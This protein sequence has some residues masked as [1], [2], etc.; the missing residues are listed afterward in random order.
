MSYYTADTLSQNVDNYNRNA[1]IQV[2]TGTNVQA[3]FLD[4]SNFK[5][6]FVDDTF[7]FIYESEKAV[8][9]IDGLED[10]P[11][12]FY[13]LVI[14][15][16]KE[17]INALI[18]CEEN[19]FTQ[20][21][22]QFNFCITNIFAIKDKSEFVNDIDQVLVPFEFD[23]DTDDVV[24]AIKAHGLMILIKQNPDCWLSFTELMQSKVNFVFFEY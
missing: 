24:S 8:D 3:K 13:N 6:A 19:S 23:V 18:V 20:V 21:I 9:I 4:Y 7:T 10:N 15:V 5:N 17:D 22:M 1:T 12:R 16:D 2:L 14:V 11:L